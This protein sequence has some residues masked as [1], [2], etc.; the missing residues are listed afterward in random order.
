MLKP[1][2]K[3]VLVELTKTDDKSKGGIHIPETAREKSIEG[4]I[5]AI[6]TGTDYEVKVGDKVLIDRYSGIDVRSDDKD[7]QLVST[8]NILAIIG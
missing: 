7:C 4:I 1:T 3:R 6:G 5:R 2:G 8:D